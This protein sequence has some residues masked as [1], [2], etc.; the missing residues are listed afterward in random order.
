MNMTVAWESPDGSEDSGIA[1][2]L[3]KTEPT[4]AVP[5]A[6]KT[7]GLRGREEV[8]PGDMEGG[9][10][11]QQRTALLLDHHQS[12]AKQGNDHPGRVTQIKWSHTVVYSPY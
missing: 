3:G 12:R 11:L 8:H 10:R 1:A 4:E 5:A 6:D 7:A 2:I 9:G